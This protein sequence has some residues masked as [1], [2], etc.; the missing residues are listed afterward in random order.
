MSVW[1]DIWAFLWESESAWSWIADFILAF[2]I[3]RFVFFPLMSFAFST[4]LPLVVVESGSMEHTGDFEKWWQEMGAWY[5]DHG[6]SKDSFK[7]YPFPNGFNQ[8]DIIFTKGS[9][10]YEK[11]DVIVFRPTVPATPVIHRIV[12]QN[13]DLTFAT[14]G[15][16]N[17]YQL[18]KENNPKNIDETSIQK[19][20]IVGK[21][22]FRIPK[23]GWIK[24]FFV[25]MISKLSAR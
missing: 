3:V 8:G 20:Q 15:D 14:K 11:G 13:E 10:H 23:L 12:H 18:T 1:K 21:A 7:D 24:L 16:H 19:Q 5:A 17:G 22:L 25:N 6:I 4:S 9:D 2:L